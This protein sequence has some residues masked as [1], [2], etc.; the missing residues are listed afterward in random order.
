MN[1]ADFPNDI[2]LLIIEHLSPRD[3]ILCRLV[4][5]QFHA[6]FSESDLNCHLLKLHYPRVRELR[7]VDN[8][9]ALD[10]P[11]AFKRVA[12]RY[13]HLKSGRPQIIEKFPLGKSFV[14]PTWARF[15]PVAPWQRHLQFEEKTAPFHYPDPLW[16]YDNGL[17]VFPNAERQRYTIYDLATGEM[18][19]ADIDSDTKVVRRIRLK[20][21][22][23]VVE[24]CEPEAY[25]QL[26]EN[27]RVHRHFATAYDIVQ[28]SKNLPWQTVFRSV[29]S[30]S[31][32]KI[33]S[34][35]SETSGRS[36]SWEC[37]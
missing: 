1:I 23:L 12:T 20:D 22:V 27:E 19:D 17:L 36:I 21:R 11:E 28:S 30:V 8:A 35:S 16:T 15:Y 5:R 34:K 25:H 2:F 18:G 37:L 14:V 9:E 6:A 4:S 7:D 3:L 24:W 32:R 29:S 10:W 26:N 13:H 33:Q 31:L